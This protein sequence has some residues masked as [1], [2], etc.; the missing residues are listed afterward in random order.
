MTGKEINILINSIFDGILSKQT[1]DRALRWLVR[2]DVDSS[3]KETALMHVWDQTT[4]DDISAEE[5]EESLRD[6]L[7]RMGGGASQRRRF[8]VLRFLKYAAVFALP[9]L[10]AAL[11]WYSARSSH[12]GSQD[13]VEVYVANGGI[14]KLTLPDGSAVTVNAGTTILY[15]RSFDSWHKERDV[16]LYGE[17]SFKVTKDAEHPFIVHTNG[18]KVKVLGTHFNVC[19][20]PSDPDVV[21]TLEEGSVALSDDD[22]ELCV[23]APGQQM[24]YRRADG[25]F[26][27]SK[28][29]VAD[30]TSWTSGGL[31]FRSKSLHDVL[32][33]LGR[34]YDVI[35]RVSPDV[36]L[37]A[38]FTMDFKE[39]EPLST[40]IDVMSGIYPE[41]RF[42]RKGGIVYVKK[43]K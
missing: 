6:L 2:E 14:R 11:T 33:Q 16:Y 18:L 38:S 21:T 15:P 43:K 40:V 5:T 24:V 1:R 22:R 7:L 12:S 39:G 27:K 37:S 35:F 13:F 32:D 10:T 28:V 19:A 17:A 30:F 23:L 8:K 3:G 29:E 34:R 42:D 9:V 41:L 26:S 4:G 25:S 20:Y 31:V 36:D